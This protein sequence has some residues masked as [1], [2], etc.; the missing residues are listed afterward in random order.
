[1]NTGR[2]DGSV[3]Y[4]TLKQAWANPDPWWPTGSVFTFRVGGDGGA[5]PESIETMNSRKD[6]EGKAEIY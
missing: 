5:T 2:F 6:S 3:A 1:M 4:V